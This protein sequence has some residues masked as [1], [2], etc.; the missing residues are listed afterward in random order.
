MNL[1]LTTDS[2]PVLAVN[3]RTLKVREYPT[4]F[5]AYEADT[6][7]RLVA[8]CADEQTPPLAPDW[9]LNLTPEA[10]ETAVS[11]MQEAN[12]AF[13]AWCARRWA[14]RGVRDGVARMV[15]NGLAGSPS[16]GATGSPRSR[17]T[18]A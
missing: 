4:A 1:A 7:W 14:N 18:P 17:P 6:E 10:Y 12:P 15:A 8:L 11:A 16:P 9:P 13:F 5:A 3:I 2:G